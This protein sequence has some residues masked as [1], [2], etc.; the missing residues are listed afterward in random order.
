MTEEVTEKAAS[1]RARNEDEV[2][3]PLVAGFRQQ[4][5]KLSWDGAEADFNIDVEPIVRN[6][7]RQH[8]IQ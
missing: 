5:E 3:Q 1:Q 7:L 4:L 6:G 8:R 2:V